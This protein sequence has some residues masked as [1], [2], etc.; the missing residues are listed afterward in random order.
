[1]AKNGDE[2]RQP[3]PPYVSFKSLDGFIGKLKETAVPGRIDHTV[4]RTYSNSVARQLI[5]AMK[6]LRLIEE[7]GT[8]TKLLMDLVKTY[9]TDEWQE[10]LTQVVFE[11]YTDLVGPL[12][13][14][15][16]TYGQLAERFRAFGAEGE[17]LQK[18]M[19]F[20]LSAVRATGSGLSPHI[21][22]APRSRPDRTRRGKRQGTRPAA[23]DPSD[24]TTAPDAQ[25]ATWTSAGSVR[26]VFPIP[27]KTAVTM[28]LPAELSS[29]D[30]AMVDTMVRAYVDRRAKA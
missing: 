20:Y 8:T 19:A 2:A 9:G 24:L 29:D 22:N 15:T 1:M 17:V 3:L 4:L 23:S 26:F 13:L 21:L 25:T 30:W 18:C 28:F 11:G 16:A 10:A 27:G 12:N 6:W 14:D 7:N 5:S